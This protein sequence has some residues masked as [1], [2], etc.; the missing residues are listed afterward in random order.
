MK[1]LGIGIAVAV[2]L[3]IVFFAP[4]FSNPPTPFSLTEV[5]VADTSEERALGLSGREVPEDY[6]MLFIFETEGSYGFWMKET[7]VPLDVIW[8]TSEGAILGILK[9]AAP[10]SYPTVFYPPSPVRYVLEVRGGTAEAR[11]WAT[12]TVLSL[13]LR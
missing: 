2:A 13:P 6:G 4:S 10:P 5:D 8:L 7:L 1:V 12:S 9:D 3:A 11:G